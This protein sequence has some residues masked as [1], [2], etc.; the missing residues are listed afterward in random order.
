MFRELFTI[1]VL[2]LPIYG[3]GVMMV[4]GVLCA[5]VL[6]KFL[7]RRVGV[8]PER[9]VD[10][11]LIALFAGVIGARVS[12]VI[13]NW[14]D[15]F[16]P[17][18]SLGTS[19][20]AAINIRAGGL[21]YYGGFLLGVPACIYYVRRHRIPTRLMMDIAAPC[22]MI[23]LAIGRIGCFLNGCCW[24]QECDAPWAVSFP[25]ESPPY[26]EQFE[27]GK[28]KPPPSLFT[29]DIRTGEPMLLSRHD[30]LANPLTR[31]AA[32]NS[33]SLRVHPTQLYSTITA[34]LIAASCVTFFGIRKSA[35]LVFSLMLV[36]EGVGRFCI[37]ML[38]TNDPL[39]FKQTSFPI[40]YSMSIGVGLIVAGMVTWFLFSKFG[41]PILD[42]P[43]KFEPS[44][45]S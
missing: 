37:E 5:I 27:Q 24:G 8:D 36:M 9:I 20:L 25:Y 40:T 2:N 41:Q 44:S 3:Y 13:E 43:A 7:A 31:D 30:A 12:H 26:V 38:R 34:L 33:R 16:V 14:N 1:P 29:H 39:F 23:G 19:L 45:E 11:G 15:Y 6:G 28:I 21:T 17:G 4:I 42:N 32:L 10:L 18:Q 22:L 35:G